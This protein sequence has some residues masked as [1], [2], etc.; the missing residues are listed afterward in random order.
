MTVATDRFVRQRATFK[1]QAAPGGDGMTVTGHGVTWGTY[2]SWGRVFLPGAFQQSIAEISAMKP[3]VMGFEHSMMAAFQPIGKWTTVSEDDIGLFLSGRISDTSLGR[4]AAVLLGDGAITGLSIGFGLDDD[5]YYIAG[6]NERFQYAGI[7][8]QYP[9]WT[10]YVYDCDLV[11][12]SIVS[13]PADEDARVM[14]VQSA[15]GSAQKALPALRQGATWEDAAY[16]MALIMGGRGSAAFADLP[17]LEHRALFQR[18]TAVYQQHGK[19]PPAYDRSPNYATV[20]FRNDERE[21]F[22]DRYLQKSLDTVIAGAAGVRGTLSEDTRAV[23]H[24]AI[25]ALQPLVQGVHSADLATALRELNE[26]AQTNPLFEG[27]L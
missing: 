1:L 6:P 12:C 17:A 16:S 22:H 15:L 24:R 18:I 19:T 21:L 4:D 20:E 2:N 13:T 11:E 25:Q 26:I 10:T 23:A 3:L 9:D 27:N 5:D 7:V 14:A 8:Y